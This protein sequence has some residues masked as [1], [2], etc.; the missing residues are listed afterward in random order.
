MFTIKTEINVC[1]QKNI[2]F[3]DYII[4][5]YIVDTSRKFERN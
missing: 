5:Y 3:N 2:K 1:L 4:D